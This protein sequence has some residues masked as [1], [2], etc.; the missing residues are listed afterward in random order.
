M[1]IVFFISYIL[2]GSA[3]WTNDIYYALI[4]L[5]GLFY[6][7]KERGAGLLCHRLACIWMIFLLWFLVPATIAGDPQFYRHIVYVTLFIFIVAGLTDPAFWRS[8]LFT[9][10][11]FWIIVL[12]IFTSAIYSWATGLFVFGQRVGILPGRLENVIYGSIW[13]LSALGLNLPAW[14][15]ERSWMEAACAIIVSLFAVAFV[16]QTRTALVGAGFLFGL[17]AFYGLYR[18]PRLG[19]ASLL[20][21][22]LLL[23]LAIWL[24]QDQPWFQSL[25]QRGDSS[26]VAI[27]RI[28]TDEWRQCGWILGCGVGFHTTQTLEGGSAIQ[29]PHNIFVALGLYTGGVSLVLFLIVAAST[30]WYAWRS[31]DSWGIYLAC[32]LIMLNF[33][34]T[35]L[36]GNPDALWPLVLLPSAL[37]FG[38]AAKSFETASPR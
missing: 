31:K 13:L 15:R 28:M 27:F 5:P 4:A 30:L 22:S 7:V 24:A 12:Y 37:I 29:H 10:A 14:I 9:R 2:P 1:L 23:G 36:I 16:L 25:L 19:L 34:G 20:A 33:D 3:K 8:T 26:R 18:A 11:L 17:W 35:K 38:R 21:A 6:L 32:S